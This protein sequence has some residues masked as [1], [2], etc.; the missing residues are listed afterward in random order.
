MQF[1]YVFKQLKT[2]NIHIMICSIDEIE[3]CD[4]KDFEKELELKR[5]SLISRDLYVMAN[6]KNGNEM[7]E[8][9]IVR[10]HQFTQEFGES[11]GAVEGE[12]EFT[13]TIKFDHNGII[14]VNSEF[15]TSLPLWAVSGLHEES[16][17]KI[18]NIYT[19][20]KEEKSNG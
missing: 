2:K 6:D 10:V 9:D 20:V 4:Y 17:E 5:Y 15:T 13:A 3:N 16:L 12:N 14:L 19:G 1:R 11:L 18:G 7:Y 8:N